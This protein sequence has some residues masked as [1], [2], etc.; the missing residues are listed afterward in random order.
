MIQPTFHADP[1]VLAEVNRAIAVSHRLHV[2]SARRRDGPLVERIAEAMREIAGSGRVVDGPALQ[3]RGFT[4]AELSEANVAR[5][6]D[7][8]NARS[9]RQVGS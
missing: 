4:R 7:I 8:A 5:A 3:L 2:R 9:V 6:R 1:A